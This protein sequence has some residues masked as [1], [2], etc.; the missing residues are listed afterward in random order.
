MAR[1]AQRGARRRAPQPQHRARL[2]GG[3]MLAG[4]WPS[5]A[6]LSVCRQCCSCQHTVQLFGLGPPCPGSHL[7][8]THP[9]SDP[10]FLQDV[11]STVPDRNAAG[12]LEDLSGAAVHSC[13][14]PSHI[15]SAICSLGLACM[16]RP[17]GIPIWILTRHAPLPPPVCCARP[18]PRPAVHLCF[19]C[20]LHLANEHGLVIQSVP[21]LDRLLISNVPAADH[22]Q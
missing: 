17:L 21:E 8:P 16:H 4:L 1:H 15:L 2:P 7:C 10:P 12:R 13:L 14:L 3:C 9:H 5:A 18:S 6:C 11:L 20:V 22:H 19:I